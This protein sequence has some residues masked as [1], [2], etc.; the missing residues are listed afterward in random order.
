MK[1]RIVEYTYD[2]EKSYKVEEKR[3]FGWTS[4]FIGELHVN[5]CGEIYHQ[6]PNLKTLKEAEVYFKKI[7]HEKRQKV[8]KKEVKRIIIK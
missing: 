1:L 5:K 4:E 7:I 2:N 3:F 6:Q 8:I